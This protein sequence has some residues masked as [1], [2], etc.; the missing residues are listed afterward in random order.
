MKNRYLNFNRT[1]KNEPILNCDKKLEQAMMNVLAGWDETWYSYN[2]LYD[3]L[4]DL[5]FDVSMAEI[6]KT[7]KALKQQFKVYYHY[8]MTDDDCNSVICGS[9]W[10]LTAHSY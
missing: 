4:L 6:K 10:F 3:E 7:M 1:K 5:G 2:G 8:L 9:G